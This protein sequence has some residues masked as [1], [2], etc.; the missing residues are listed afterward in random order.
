MSLHSVSCS[1]FQTTMTLLGQSR[2]SKPYMAPLGHVQIF[3][4]K[5]LW[6][7]RPSKTQLIVCGT[8]RLHGVKKKAKSFG[9]DSHFVFAF[10]LLLVFVFSFV[11]L[12]FFLFVFGFIFVIVFIFALVFSF[13]ICFVLFRF[14]F[15]F[16]FLLF[17]LVF[18]SFVD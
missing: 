9:F 18:V 16:K 8:S 11:F 3:H 1:T 12:L 13:Y 14:L 2:E 5:M 4:T 6:P 17:F 10:I 15:S 7:S